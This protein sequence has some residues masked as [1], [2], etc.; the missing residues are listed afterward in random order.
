MD[1]KLIINKT[2]LEVFDTFVQKYGQKALVLYPEFDDIQIYAVSIFNTRYAEEVDFYEHDSF[3]FYFNYI[4][5]PKYAE[6]IVNV[7]TCRKMNFTEQEMMAAIAHEL[8]HIKYTNINEVDEQ[9]K[10]S[11]I[12]SDEFTCDIGLGKPLSSLLNKFINS[13]DFPEEMLQNIRERLMYISLNLQ[14][15][16]FTQ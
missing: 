10:F 6:I 1:S 4:A 11:E 12:Y 14:T 5:E 8:G 2:N 3:G 15:S 13:G 7:E 9:D 16:S